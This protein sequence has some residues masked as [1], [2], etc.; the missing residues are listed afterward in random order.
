MQSQLRWDGHVVRMNN[1]RIPKVLMYSQFDNEQ[2]SV[3]WPWLRY[4]AKLKSNLSAVNVLHNNFQR[5]A[6]DRNNWKYLCQ[7]DISLT[8][9]EI[10]DS[11]KRQK[12]KSVSKYSFSYIPIS[13]LLHNMSTCMHVTSKT[14]VSYMTQT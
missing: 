4:K 10:S 7:S 11:P 12:T 1:I 6:L 3:G 5:V 9:F 8:D 2:R 14:K 13:L